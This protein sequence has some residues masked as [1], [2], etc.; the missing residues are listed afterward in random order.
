[1]VMG[2]LFWALGY[3]HTYTNQ[4]AEHSENAILRVVLPVIN[5]ILPDFTRLDLRAI[6]VEGGLVNVGWIGMNV[7]YALLYT[8]MAMAVAAVLFYER[9]M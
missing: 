5:T 6:V 4:L 2:F 1:V 8:V 3:G 9:E 7:G